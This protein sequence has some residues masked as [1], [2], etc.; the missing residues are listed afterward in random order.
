VASASAAQL[1][2]E[3]RRPL[4]ADLPA[5][6]HSQPMNMR[7]IKNL[8]LC[9]LGMV[10]MTGPVFAQAAMA[11]GAE[12]A[13]AALEKKWL[14]SQKT[15][16]AS[17]LEPLLADNIVDTSTDGKLITGKAAVMADA[18]TVKWASAE[19]ENVQ[20]TMH[21]DAAVVTAI[22]TGKGT[23]TAGK[24]VNVHERFTDTWVKSADGH[25]LCV[26]THGSTIKS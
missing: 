1:A 16:D 7:I 22:F 9:L 12:Q 25:W 18:K 10:V 2:A 26:A 11:T 23:D 3:V 21:G 4:L 13:V 20:V 8:G 19:Y 5:P 24:P 14:Q 6:A 15:N 17:L